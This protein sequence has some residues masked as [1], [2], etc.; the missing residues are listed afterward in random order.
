M[1][2]VAP[3]EAAALEQIETREWIDSFD[4]VLRGGD[5]AR[6]VRLLDALRLRARSP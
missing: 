4:Y 2:N 6:T 5:N 3:D 1:K